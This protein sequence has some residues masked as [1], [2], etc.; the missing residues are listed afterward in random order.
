[1]FE[2]CKYCKVKINYRGEPNYKCPNCGERG[3]LTR[4]ICYRYRWETG[5]FFEEC[6][7]CESRFICF[8][9]R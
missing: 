9:R 2:L 8:T 5:E 1:M 7:T 6:D 3:L 4:D